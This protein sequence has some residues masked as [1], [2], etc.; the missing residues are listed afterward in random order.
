MPGQLRVGLRAQVRCPLS[1]RTAT[2]YVFMMEME[3]F[4]FMSPIS[5][6]RNCATTASWES[7]ICLMKTCKKGL[8]LP[9]PRNRDPCMLA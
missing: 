6:M 4:P 9:T 7:L 3:A 1:C 5:R 2:I 8:S